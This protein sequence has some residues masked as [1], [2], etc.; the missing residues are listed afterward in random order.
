MT[1]DM[2]FS[3]TL[4][5]RAKGLFS[6]MEQMDGSITLKTI[7]GTCREGRYELASILAELE[8]AGLVTRCREKDARGRFQE[9]TY[10]LAQGKGVPAKKRK[11]K[12][13]MDDAACRPDMT[14]SSETTPDL[15]D[16]DQMMVANSAKTAEP[17]FMKLLYGNKGYDIPMSYVETM[18]GFYPDINVEQ[19]IRDAA[20]WSVAN[21]DKTK[22]RT[23]TWKQYINGWLRR[24]QEQAL[25][26]N[27]ARSSGK[28]SAPDRTGQYSNDDVGVTL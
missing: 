21:E 9:M 3:N 15:F 6:A 20:A 10:Q 23:G 13:K 25:A 17:V 27:E 24:D 16:M 12:P 7:S 22:K 8:H 19:S 2:L 5:L 1:E 18:K 14:A 26:R 11:A 4:S 28:K